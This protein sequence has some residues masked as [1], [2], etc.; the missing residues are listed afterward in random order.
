MKSKL[1]ST[2]IVAAALMLPVAGYSQ[3]DKA[4][5][6]AKKESHG[7]VDDAMISTTIKTEYSKD[8]DVSAM[9]INVDTDKGVVTLR[10]TA[11]SPAE[12][13]KAVTIAKNVSGVSSVN[14]QIKVEPK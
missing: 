14:N 9:R 6:P 1:V 10:G 5:P 13:E 3:Y 8:K 11:K 4:T 7:V 2:C 12:A